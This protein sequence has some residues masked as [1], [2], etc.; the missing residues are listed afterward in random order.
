[1][2]VISIESLKW[3]L[4]MGNTTNTMSF[5]LLLFIKNSPYFLFSKFNFQIWIQKVQLFYK[6]LRRKS[7]FQ[8]GQVLLWTGLPHR[9]RQ[10]LWAEFLVDALQEAIIV[11]S[12]IVAAAAQPFFQGMAGVRSLYSLCKGQHDRVK[13]INSGKRG[14][15]EIIGWYIKTSYP[16]LW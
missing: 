7:L 9:R 13:A 12:H 16:C 14:S 8:E 5:K 6:H 10:F 2:F 1:M 3:K 15:K 11:A 4:L